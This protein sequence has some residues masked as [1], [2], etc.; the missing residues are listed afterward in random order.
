MR[1]MN[2]N[3]GRELSG[4]EHLKQSIAVIL[5]TPIGTR[6]QRREFGSRIYQYIDRSLNDETLSEIYMAASEALDIWEPRFTVQSI[7]ATY[8]GK[9][10]ATILI[11]GVYLITGEEIILENIVL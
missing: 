1:G 10:T 6:V 4:I 7:K 11:K 8:I 9:G 5:T 3:T 2:R